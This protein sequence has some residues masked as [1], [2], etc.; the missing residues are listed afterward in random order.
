M[1]EYQYYEFQSIDRPLD[2]ED[3]AALRDLS[4]RAQITATSFVNTY[5][6]GDFKGSPNKLMAEWFDLHLYLANWATHRLMIRLPKRV[7]DQKRLETILSPVDCAELTEAGDNLIL[8][9]QCHELNI[10][11]E[12]DEGPGLLASMA[13]LRADILNGDLR[14]FYLLW[15]IAVSEEDC[16]PD[17]AP[18]PMPGIG[19][20]TGQ[21]QA[22]ADFFC[23]DPDLVAAAAEQEAATAQEPSAAALHAAL[24]ALPD[25]L[26]LD[27]LTRLLSGNQHVAYELRRT[28]RETLDK[29]AATPETP[30]RTAGDL[31][32]RA[33]AIA[34]ARE[35]EAAARRVAEERR[36]TEA[37]A[38]QQRERMD[39][40]A[41][42]GEAVWREVEFE[43]DRRNA[44]GYEKAAALLQEL[45]QLA[46]DRG[47]SA[48]FQ[49]RLATIRARHASK[50]T[51]I[52]R[53]DRML[54]LPDQ[55]ALV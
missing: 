19:P 7:V 51:F 18:E 23:I 1:S 35:Q 24:A 30:R 29:P 4:S 46:E 38:R 53:L 49:R 10:D 3:R 17:D 39:T 25:A 41:K 31:R 5:Q 33:K 54:P 50:Q 45:R 42:R 37:A 11:T 13:P 43:I 20:V 27:F 40:L 2:N 26:K 44:T 14:V 12:W 34:E 52:A 28:L 47:S 21:L 6:Y 16:I 22:F 8:D 36:R 48:M 55:A 9:I 15:L 32:A